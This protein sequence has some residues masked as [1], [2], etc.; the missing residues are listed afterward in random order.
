M[1]AHAIGARAHSV[2]VTR[3][4]RNPARRPV[5]D[6]ARSK[7]ITGSPGNSPPTPAPQRQNPTPNNKTQKPHKKPQKHRTTKNNDTK[8]TNRKT[9]PR[10][11]NKTRTRRHP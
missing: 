7:R 9:K 5:H 10:T 11:Q 6:M 1:V 4:S 8:P 2:H 3:A